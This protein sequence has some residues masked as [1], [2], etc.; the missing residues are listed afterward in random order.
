MG[1]EWVKWVMGIKEDICVE[2]WMLYVSN[3]SL[4]SAPENNITL[5]VSY[6]EVK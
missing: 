3:E 5:Y 1:G 6:L 4:N 2:H